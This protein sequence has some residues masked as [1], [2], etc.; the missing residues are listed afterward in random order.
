MVMIVVCCEVPKRRLNTEREQMEFVFQLLTLAGVIPLICF[1]SHAHYLFVA[2]ITDAFYATGIVI[3]YGIFY[4]VHLSLLKITYEGVDERT[5]VHRDDQTTEND[6][7]IT[8]QIDD[9]QSPIQP[10][11]ND[12]EVALFNYK[13][14][15]IASLVFF[16]TLCYQILITT[17]YVFLPINQSVESLPSHLF[18]ILQVASAL[19][20]SLLA[21]KIVFGI[22]E[23]PSL[24]AMSSAIR[25]FLLKKKDENCDLRDKRNWDTLDEEEKITH[26][27][28]ELCDNMAIRA[29]LANQQQLLQQQSPQE[30]PPQEQPPKEMMQLQKQPLEPSDQQDE[31]ET[32]C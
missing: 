14:M 10:T 13:A 25:D 29:K 20:V 24:S 1:A 11:D 17:L 23:T 22:E 21:Y 9:Q 3:Y 30:Q 31:H 2:A 15:M 7:P 26:L 8:I 32:H 16:V 19:L 5:P 6:Q 27:L 18:S 4:Y 12:K 28:H